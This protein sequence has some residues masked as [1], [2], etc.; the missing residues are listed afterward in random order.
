[1]GDRFAGGL[2]RTADERLHAGEEFGKREGLRQI[3]VTA[4]LQPEYAVVEGG[5]RAEDQHGDGNLFLTQETQEREAVELGQ[6]EVEHGGV[7]GDDPREV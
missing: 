6:V 4:A 1:M 2:A 7:V 3:I 5:P